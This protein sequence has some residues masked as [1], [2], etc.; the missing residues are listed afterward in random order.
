MYIDG[1]AILATA[2]LTYAVVE[3]MKVWFGGLRPDFLARCD[4]DPVEG[5]CTGK[6][7]LVNDGRRSFPSGHA[8]YSFSAMTLIACVL[9]HKAARMRRSFFTTLLYL[10]PLVWAVRIT[11]TRWWEN[12]HDA[13]D[14][15]AG[16]VVGTSIALLCFRIFYHSGSCPRN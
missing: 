2:S 8:A 14:I 3:T 12:R 4:W 13:M 10:L 5:K 7:K 1:F 16:V 9:F 6:E 15:A 11:T